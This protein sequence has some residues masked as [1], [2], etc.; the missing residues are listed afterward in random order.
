MVQDSTPSKKPRRRVKPVETVR[1]RVVKQQSKAP[2]PQRVRKTMGSGYSSAKTGFAKLF[3]P[4]NFVLRPL[5]TKPIRFVGRILATILLLNFVRGAARELRDVV[6]PDRK[7]TT[8]LT[9]A[10]FIFAIV[11]GLIITITDF[12]LD[13]IFKRI[14]IK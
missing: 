1:E 12:G 11:F 8:Q 2:K 3:H 13:R 7:Q 10:V 9:L 6:W 4:L 14:L 5:R